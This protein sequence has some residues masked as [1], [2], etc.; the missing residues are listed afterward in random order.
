MKIKRNIIHID[1][2]KCDGCGQCVS[3][4]AEGAIEMVNGKARLAA[5]N[6]C[7]GLA[8]CIGEC[9]VGAITLVEREADAF[10]PEAVEEYLKRRTKKGGQGTEDD[11]SKPKTGFPLLSCPSTQISMFSSPCEE[12]NQPVSRT[13][14]PS[15]LTHW[16][17]QI[18]LIPA[19]APFL[20]GANLL[21]AS[22]CTPAAYP[23]FHGD[24]LKGK[25]VMIGCPKFDDTEEYINKFAQIFSTAGIKSITIVI[26]EVPCC[27]KMPALIRQGLEKSGKEIPVEIVIVGINGGIHRHRP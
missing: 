18:R 1:E 8:A 24:L 16:P 23:N 9:P 13:D 11:L 26:M 19:S 5:E 10:D 12:A 20:K 25:V 27:S 4:C 14:S 15:S 3:A 6:Y 17:V 2:E 22:D 21:I 7:D